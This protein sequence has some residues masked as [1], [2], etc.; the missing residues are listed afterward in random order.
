LRTD[1]LQKWR[2]WQDAFAA[3]QS[4][5]LNGEGEEGE[6]VDGTQQAKKNRSC[7]NVVASAPTVPRH[8]RIGLRC[9]R[10]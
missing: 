6:E 10:F 9:F 5:D 3:N 7:E 2:D 8:A 4:I 1:L